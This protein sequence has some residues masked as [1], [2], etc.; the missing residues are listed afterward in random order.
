MDSPLS[1]MTSATKQSITEAFSTLE[2]DWYIPET[3]ITE[4]CKAIKDATKENNWQGLHDFIQA[5]R[6]AV[7]DLQQSNRD[8]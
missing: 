8:A 5:T 7:V 3:R 1:R 4:M 6:S 2:D